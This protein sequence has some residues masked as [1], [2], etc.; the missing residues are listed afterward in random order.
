MKL[1]LTSP[2][3]FERSNVHSAGMVI[4]AFKQLVRI[5]TARGRMGA[6]WGSSWRT[7]APRPAAHP[8]LHRLPPPPPPDPTQNPPHPSPPAPRPPPHPTA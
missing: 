8:W 1:L 5:G 7:H 6:A 2:E 4:L 3:L